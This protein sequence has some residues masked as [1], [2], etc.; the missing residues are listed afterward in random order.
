MTVSSE[1]TG[2]PDASAFVPT[3]ILSPM[4]I[5]CYCGNKRIGGSYPS[6]HKCGACTKPVKAGGRV[7]QCETCKNT[8]CSPCGA[9]KIKPATVDLVTQP[10]EI[11]DETSSPPKRT[12]LT[13][14]P[15]HFHPCD[16]QRLFTIVITRSS[17]LARRKACS[18]SRGSVF[19]VCS[20]FSRH[21]HTHLF[22]LH[23]WKVKFA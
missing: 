8:T 17:F 22:T 13:I 10:A 23:M 1:V 12:K 20:I 6:A 4:T 5:E 18:N 16:V 19:T 9:H 7:W 2:R 11:V 21:S 14:I 15:S 3:S